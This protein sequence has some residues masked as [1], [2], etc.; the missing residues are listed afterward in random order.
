[1]ILFPYATFL[2]A[3]LIKTIYILV[4]VYCAYVPSEQNK[5][6]SQNVFLL[7][8]QLIA[9]FKFSCLRSLQNFSLS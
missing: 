3:F 7:R 8:K 9:K 5:S 4:A 2:I 1:M 6:V